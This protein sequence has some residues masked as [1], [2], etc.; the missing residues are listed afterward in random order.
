MNLHEKLLEIQKTVSYL[1]KD[2]KGFQYQYVSSSQTV[3]A[4]RAKMDE[5]GVML[6]PRVTSYKVERAE[7]ENDKGK[8]SIQYFTEI[9]MDMEWVDA[10]NPADKLVCPWY[11]QGK[12]SGE[13]GVGKALTYGEKYFLLKFFHIATDKDDPDAFQER[14]V[15]A[16][17]RTKRPPGQEPPPPPPPHTEV[18]PDRLKNGNHVPSNP[19]FGKLASMTG[20]VSGTTDGKDWTYWI[21]STGDME[22]L[23]FDKGVAEVA[24]LAI[25]DNAD[26]ELV[27]KLKRS[28]RTGD[29]KC[30]AE[31]IRILET[32]ELDR[33][34]SR[35]A[36]Y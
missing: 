19:W 32:S 25:Q 30:S 5:L 17:K 11:A 29:E 33:Q 1:M 13:K 3:G 14:R 28:K 18:E 23:T 24:G 36:N 7:S 35:A 21:L 9:A 15:E 16:G 2:N 31:S 34:F 10:S 20:P 4:I 6:I 27:W 26:V 8:I 12:D 22:L